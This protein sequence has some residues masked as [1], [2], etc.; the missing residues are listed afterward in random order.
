M[1][2]TPYSFN[3]H[4]INDGTNYTAYLKGVPPQ[5]EYDPIEVPRAQNFPIDAG[6]KMSGAYYPVDIV[7]V[8]T[9]YSQMDQLRAW[10]DPRDQNPKKFICKDL[11]NSSKQWYLMAR[12]VSNP[13]IK[14]SLMTINLY[15]ADP[16]WQS[17]TINYATISFATTGAKGTITVSG[18]LNVQPYIYITPVTAGTEGYAYRRFVG[19][20]NP[21]NYAQPDYGIN[22]VATTLDTEALGTASKCGTEGYDIRA[23]V[24]GT[25]ANR[26]IQDMNTG[27][28]KIWSTMSL[29][30]GVSV[31][32]GG[33]IGTAAMTSGTIQLANTAANGT[34]MG[35]LPVPGMI[36]FDSE[37]FT[38]TG[39]NIPSRKLTGVQNGAK[40]TTKAAHAPGAV[41]Y[42]LEHEVYIMYGNPDATAPETDDTK[43]PIFDLTSTN[44]QWDYTSFYDESSSRPGAWL[45]AVYRT[46]SKESEY[47]GG[48]R[49]TYAATAIEM[50]M[51]LKSYTLYNIPKAEA[52]AVIWDYYNPA[53]V[54][55]VITQD[56]EKFRLLTTWPAYA[57]LYSSNNGVNWTSQWQEATPAAAATWATLAMSGTAGTAAL[58]TP[59]KFLRYLMNGNIGAG[60]SA[61][62]PNYAAM[63]IKT[64]SVLFPSTTI[65]QVD[66]GAEIANFYLDVTLTNNTTDEWIKLTGGVATSATLTVDCAGKTVTN[67]DN[68]NA[69]G[70][71]SWSS[72]RQE[73][74][75]LMPGTNEIQCDGGAFGTISMI[76]GWRDKAL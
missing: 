62:T 17:E 21:I 49:T 74:F 72:T 68:T 7:M 56:G 61:S 36:K 2:L 69:M 48:T 27:T 24:D 30:P 65:P 29:S 32:L 8:G 73:W 64:A 46:L 10:F 14:G 63:S 66:F 53:G 50:G 59:C 70:A 20:Y 39:K 76:F 1:R 33:T 11:N 71:I 54:G 58:S 13:D 19:I 34:A 6:V 22:L 16:V 44:T 41:G 4:V 45:P 43:K 9:P 67:P 42:W 23:F 26:W 28:S 51:M 37:V 15:S 40:D 57:G 5:G 60:T 52:G 12:P 35:K 31:T 75:D 55:T 25:E 3:A 18:A 38:Y 47:Y